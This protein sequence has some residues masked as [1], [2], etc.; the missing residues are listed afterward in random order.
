MFPRT[1]VIVRV[2]QTLEVTM[3][4]FSRC[5]TADHFEY[6][7]LH[8]HPYFPRRDIRF[9]A[10]ISNTRGDHFLFIPRTPFLVRVFQTLEFLSSFYITPKDTRVL[11]TLQVTIF[12][13]ISTSPFIPRTPVIARVCQTLQVTIIGSPL[14]VFSSHGHP[15][16]CAYFKHSR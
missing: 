4:S 12:G 13:S 10:R 6:K 11:Q 3:T 1:P 2:F 8:S 9:R 5:Q 15:F 7:Y 14:Q 16:S